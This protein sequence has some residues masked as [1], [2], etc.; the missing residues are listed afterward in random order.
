MAKQVV[1]KINRDELIYLK[2]IEFSI[3]NNKKRSEFRKKK[4]ELS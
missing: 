4:N 2:E 1:Q 3:K